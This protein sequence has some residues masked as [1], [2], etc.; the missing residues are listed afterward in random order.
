M[1]LLERII[2]IH[3]NN[4]NELSNLV[5]ILNPIIIM[6]SY[7]IYNNKRRKIVFREDMKGGD[8]KEIIIKKNK[9]YYN[10]EYAKSKK[11]I[12]NIIYLL[13]IEG[14]PGCGLII[15]NKK[16]N[17][18]NI[19]GISNY[20]EC[21]SIDNEDQDKIYKVGDIM[22][23]IILE[24]CRL[25]GITNVSLKDNSLLKYS[26]CSIKLKYLRVITHGVP[27]YC[28]YGFINKDDEENLK[29]NLEKF[30]ENKMVKVEKIDIILKENIDDNSMYK[31]AKY[32]LDD[33]HEKYK[34]DKISI[35]RYVNKLIVYCNYEEKK[36]KELREKKENLGK[37]YSNEYCSIINK[38]L[39]PL[40][41][42]NGYKILS[43]DSYLLD[44]DKYFA[45]ILTKKIK[46]I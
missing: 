37:Q 38:I 11:S 8:I 44:L 21:I 5:E 20:K 2:S 43:S 32:I 24:E 26:D 42:K 39:I 4:Q 1:E 9:Y 41:L 14:L 35:G 13:S 40:Y 34:S 18:A 19:Q 12:D 6:D 33:L 46:N 31:K 29:K 25:I 27:Y 23:Q 10:V 22:M 15:I 17:L 45:L 7:K 30:K 28:K 36:I 3:K 16:D